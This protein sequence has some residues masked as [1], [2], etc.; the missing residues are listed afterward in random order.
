MPSEKFLVS[1]KP[2]N[3]FE[4]NPAVDVPI[5]SQT[6]NKSVLVDDQGTEGKEAKDSG[7]FSKL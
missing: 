7:C 3:F 5:S 4:K 2:S 1:P 6:K